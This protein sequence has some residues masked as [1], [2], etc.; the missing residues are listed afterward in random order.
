LNGEV[1]TA[2]RLRRTDGLGREVNFT[3]TDILPYANEIV[4]GDWFSDVAGDPG[5][6]SFSMEQEVAQALGAAV[7]DEIE[8]SIG[9]ITLSATL[10]SIRTVDWRTMT[11]N[12]YIIFQPGVLDRFSPNWLTS[13]NEEESQSANDSPIKQQSSFIQTLVRQYPTAVVIE[14]GDII[15]QI[16]NIITR[17]TQGLEMILL[18]VLACG[19]MV[20][21]AAIGVSFDERLRENAI[22]RTLG[23]SRKIVV[24]ALTVEYAALGAIAGLIASVGAETILYFVQTNF[25]NL[26]PSLHPNLWLIGMVSGVCLIT[27]LGLLRSRE[28]ITVPPLQSLQRIG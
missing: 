17:V 18:L 9:G 22:L 24:G 8:F 2:E 10:T 28:I 5:G 1:L 13:L 20:L 11:P 26:A 6:N 14:L 7:G 12:F 3:Q 4:A 23:S 25:F 21:F 15:N 27:T 16:R 19:A